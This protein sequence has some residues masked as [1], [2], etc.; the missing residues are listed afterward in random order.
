MSIFEINGGRIN[1]RYLMHKTKSDLAYV[2]L[3][4]LREWE[5]SQDENTS[6]RA[7]LATAE[8]ELDEL[9]ASV[10]GWVDVNEALT[11]ECDE[12]RAEL[13]AAEEEINTIQKQFR[14]CANHGGNAA[15]PPPAY[16]PKCL[17]G[18]IT[19]HS[20]E[21]VPC[22]TCATTKADRDRLQEKSEHIAE[23]FADERL[24]AEQA[25]SALKAAQEENERLKV[26]LGNAEFAASII[27]TDYQALESQLAAAQQSAKEQFALG[28]E[29]A[30]EIAN[31]AIKNDRYD[32]ITARV[33]RDTIREA[34]KEPK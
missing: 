14:L 8:Q 11:K 9:K 21:S 16:C 3:D 24:R 28:M 10:V 2:V 12:L 20:R 32:G 31:N 25:E 1:H 18:E 27:H 19:D 13:L 33:I 34:N 22:Y 30:A 29:R 15:E 4:Y 23:A 5:K 7:S 26:D 6:L 17:S